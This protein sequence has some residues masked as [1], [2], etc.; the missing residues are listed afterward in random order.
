LKRILYFLKNHALSKFEC[1]DMQK[2]F[3][4]VSNFE[5]VNFIINGKYSKIF[6]ENPNYYVS[7]VIFQTYK[8][9]ILRSVYPFGWFLLL[10]FSPIAW[11]KTHIAHEWDH[12]WNDALQI[13]STLEPILI[14]VTSSKLLALLGISTQAV[15]SIPHHAMI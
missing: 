11:A 8:N 1:F 2:H 13:K 15:G 6:Y 3:W 7:F 5:H 4:F 12:L 10:C 9:A 14:R